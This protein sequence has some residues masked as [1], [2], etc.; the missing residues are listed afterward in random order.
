MTAQHDT[1]DPEGQSWSSPYGQG[2]VSAP[3]TLCD[4]QTTSL[5]KPDDLQNGLESSFTE[6]GLRA[7]LT[8][9]G[10]YVLGFLYACSARMLT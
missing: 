10:G 6:G 7:W 9:L 3:N 5:S 2:A 1:M 4:V 8:V